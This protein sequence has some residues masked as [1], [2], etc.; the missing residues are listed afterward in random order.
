MV[1]DTDLVTTTPTQPKL[2]DPDGWTRWW[3]PTE[4]PLAGTILGYTDGAF[5][6][7]DSQVNF[8]ATIN[9]YKYFANGFTVN[10]A[11][12]GG[13]DLSRRGV[14][15]ATSNVNWRHYSINFGTQSNWYV[16]NYAVDASHWFDPNW[17][18]SPQPTASQV[19][20]PFFPIEA[21]QAEAFAIDVSSQ[22]NNLYYKDPS[23]A[24][25]DLHLLLNIYD[26][27]GL[28]RPAGYRA[29]WIR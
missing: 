2:L 8:R 25:G 22:M 1:S 10:A 13:L 18:G 7:K 11:F 14:F 5:G 29:K 24:G 28:K 27:Q 3:N 4:F 15:M 21:N 26:W 17:P 23:H 9:P 6:M 19:P 20:D 16:F 12:P